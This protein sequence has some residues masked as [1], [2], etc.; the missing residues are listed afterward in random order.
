M[1][2]RN[3]AKHNSKYSISREDYQQQRKSK[4]EPPIIE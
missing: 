3:Q 1:A 2:P 4:G